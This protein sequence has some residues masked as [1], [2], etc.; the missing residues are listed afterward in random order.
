MCESPTSDVYEEGRALDS[1]DGTEYGAEYL[2]FSNGQRLWRVLDSEED[3]WA[4]GMVAHTDGN[5]VGWFPANSWSARV[6]QDNRQGCRFAEGMVADTSNNNAGQPLARPEVAELV[7][8]VDCLML[9]GS[10]ALLDFLVPYDVSAWRRLGRVMGS[11]CTASK[12]WIET[13]IQR[14]RLR[15]RHRAL[16]RFPH[17]ATDIERYGEPL[18]YWPR[19]YW[20]NWRVDVWWYF[21]GSAR[22]A[23]YSLYGE[24]WTCEYTF[25]MNSLA[26]LPAI[27]RN[28]PETV[29]LYNRLHLEL[30]SWTW[31]YEDPFWQEEDHV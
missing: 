11:V 23:T 2:S 24:G 28:I 25:W 6:E 9:A 17:L 10:C 7:A 12:T 31:D 22:G 16:E 21:D 20:L 19:P 15:L 27:H 1:F 26:E 3:R 30:S 13:Y 29:G 5:V 14:G 4:K 8:A 18:R